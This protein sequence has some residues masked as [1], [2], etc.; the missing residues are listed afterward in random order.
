MTHP[1]LTADLIATAVLAA[2]RS[3]GDDP[4]RAMTA[5]PKRGDPARRAVGPAGLVLAE[6][7]GRTHVTLCRVLGL[8]Q[9]ALSAAGRRPGAEA[10]I[11]AVRRALSSTTDL[12]VVNDTKPTG[13]TA[14][15]PPPAA[16]KAPATPTPATP[17]PPAAAPRIDHTAAIAE[18]LARRKARMGGLTVTVAGVEADAA[19]IGATEP[20]GCV[21]PMGDPRAPDYRSCRAP[22]LS[23]RMYCAEHL[24]KAGMKAVPKAVETV[25]RVAAPYADRE[26]G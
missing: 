22:P 2:A 6:V 24:K 25:G 10:A 8:A 7:T 17:P 26:A 9:G 15:A 16:Q 12:P 4:I 14:L 20:G 1:A 3:F 23:G 5:T 18:A 13:G 21:W 19:L 11:T